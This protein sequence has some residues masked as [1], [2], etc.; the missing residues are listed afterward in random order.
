MVKKNTAITGLAKDAIALK[1]TV[2]VSEESI[3][4]AET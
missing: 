3:E 2:E 4:I 1:F